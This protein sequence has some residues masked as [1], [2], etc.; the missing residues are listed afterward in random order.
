MR[1]Q[2]QKPNLPERYEVLHRLA[3]G[4]LGSTWVVL[5]KV[6]GQHRVAKIFEKSQGPD[7]RNYNHHLQQIANAIPHDS[8]EHLLLPL[9]AGE[10]ETNY[11]QIFL[12]LPSSETLAQAIERGLSLQESFCKFRQMTKALV[13]LHSHGIIHCDIKPSNILLQREETKLKAYLIDFG[14]VQTQGNDAVFILGTYAYLHP[15]LQIRGRSHSSA[16]WRVRVRAAVGSY[17]DVYALGVVLLEMLTG[18]RDVPAIHTSQNLIEALASN[19]SLSNPQL[20]KNIANLIRQ[21]LSVG[22]GGAGITA[23]ALVPAVQALASQIAEGD[24][25]PRRRSQDETQPKSSGDLV[26]RLQLVAETMIA[27]TGRFVATSEALRTANTPAQDADTIAHVERIFDHG[28]QRAKRVWRISLLMAITV[29]LILAAMIVIAV[30]LTVLTG[31]RQWA[32]IFGGATVPVIIGAIIWKP[33]DRVFRAAVL[34]QQIEMIHVQTVAGITSTTVLEKRI[35]IFGAAINQLSLLSRDVGLSIPQSSRRYSSQNI[36][37]RSK[38]QS[39][40]E[41]E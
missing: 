6:A 9:E 25:L 35:E 18:S 4:A 30:I 39:R 27:V 12:F 21:M 19:E 32:V 26:E 37:S 24:D 7:V 40:K 36:K 33:F 17:I 41:L 29:F 5:D 28:L 3:V 2:P 14:M 10:T 11:Y 20:R 8:V 16:T 22:P 31:E 13:A 15:A 38:F 34:T 1:E 23:T